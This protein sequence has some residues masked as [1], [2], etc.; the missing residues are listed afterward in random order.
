LIKTLPCSTFRAISQQKKSKNVDESGVFGVLCSR[1]DTPLSFTNMYG[2]EKFSYADMLL[3]S[4][5]Q[6]YG[7]TRKYH[8][9]YDLGCKYLAH[10][11]TAS[12]PR[13]ISDAAITMTIPSLH[14]IGHGNA[15]LRVFHAKRNKGLG[16]NDGEGS[17]RFWS[18]TG[19]YHTITKEMSPYKRIEQLEDV[20]RDVRI[21][22]ISR[23][24]PL[25]KRKLNANAE[26]IV[27]NRAKFVVLNVTEADSYR[28]WIEEKQTL[29]SKTPK[30][31]KTTASG[32]RLHIQSKI[33]ETSFYKHD[34][35]S[36]ST[37][38]I[39]NQSLIKKGGTNTSL[40]ANKKI[41]VAMK[42]IDALFTQYNTRYPR[43]IQYSAESVEVTNRNEGTFWQD[44]TINHDF[45][46]KQRNIIDIYCELKRS[47]EEQEL[48]QRDIDLFQR[49]CLD[50]IATLKGDKVY[51]E[52][53][54]D[55][56]KVIQGFLIERLI[57]S[58]VDM[59]KL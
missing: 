14:V 52:T 22:K 10:L 39:F 43:E 41:Q 44:S 45:L 33:L 2:G 59:S 51:S 13:I 31:D 57:D 12:V 20:V 53:L 58:I 46:L 36:R 38:G 7:A 17:E 30:I 50:D 42:D 25:L 34:I 23:L 48:I 6:K 29:L 1:H 47:E 32:F 3:Q 18:H 15:C 19:P 16:K 24:A 26:S 11:K 49:H 27:Q 37:P 4:L 40:A 54:D 55:E 28:L 5:I 56:E 9:A 35:H 21:G 8:V